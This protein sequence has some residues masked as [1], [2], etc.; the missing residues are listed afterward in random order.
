MKIDS[1]EKILEESFLNYSAFVLQRRAIP[2]ARDGLKY[3]GR[4]ILHAQF[5]DK[6]DAKHPFKKSQKSVAAAT[7]FS[8]V[9]GDSSAYEQIIRMGRPLVQRY[10]L[11]EFNGNQGTIIASNDYSAPRYTESRL[12]ALG[13]SMFDFINENT[14]PDGAWSPTYDEEGLFP[15]VLPSV[16]YYNLCNGSF[17]SIGV[18]LISS[19][20]QFNLREMNE[21]I[22]KLIDDPS[23]E[24]DLLPDFASG[25]IL[26]NPQTTAASLA[27]GE[28]KSALIRGVVKHLPKEKCIEITELPYGVYTN[29]ICVELQK[30]LDGG[31]PPFKDFVD[32][33]KQGVRIRVYT[34]S[35]EAC[36]K[37]LY[38]NTSVQKHYT[39]KLIML[40][41]GKLPKLFTLK[42]AIM[43][44]IT[45][46]KSVFRKHYEYKLN[47]L[48]ARAEVL[49][50]LIKAYSILDDVITCIKRSA[51]KA[52]A[53]V[54]LM[55]EFDFTRPQAEA[56][57]ELKLHRLTNLDIQK[58]HEELKMNLAEQDEI[59]EVLSNEQ[60]FNTRLKAVYGTVADAFGDKRRTRIT[61]EDSWESG[62]DGGKASKDFW[63]TTVPERG[64]YLAAYNQDDE[65]FDEVANPG[66]M[67]VEADC[68]YVLITNQMRGF[69]RN[70]NE[71][72]LGRV[73][74]EDMFKLKDGETVAMIVK[75]DDLEN[76][77]FVNLCDE[78][79]SW[80]SLHVSFIST[81]AS[82]RGKKLVSGKYNVQ[83]FE[84]CTESSAYPKMK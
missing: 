22:C 5:K 36:E 63:L 27:A 26:L 77:E 73:K 56:I 9:H 54:N 31:K 62:A 35:P 68:E 74:W 65:V 78:D 82:K 38:K 29:T 18:G 61:E 23:V 60:I 64:A 21:T 53:I 33:T 39:I 17:G 48:K 4:Q 3:T 43:A 16:G 71:F 66:K 49:N 28:G 58:L 41:N 24:V 32:L 72:M 44:H 70:G 81:A 84:F 42:E 14:L 19:I 67:R 57:C 20:P 59:S 45:H 13:I 50:G 15:L 40:H 12:S 8:Y 52:N 25:G 37:W 11:E 30:A 80:Y 76:F 79:G 1:L 51:D 47:V 7:S 6:L 75:K 83:N 55:T 34:D 10:F 69:L 2:D 46:S